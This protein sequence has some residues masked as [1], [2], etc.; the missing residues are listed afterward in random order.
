MAVQTIDEVVSALDRIIQQS[1]DHNSRI[2]YFAALYRRVTC[3]VR[4]GLSSGQF[5]NGPLLERLDVVFASRYLDALAAFQAGAVPTRSWMQAFQG[6]DDAGLLILQQLLSGMNAHINLDLGIASAQ[7]SPGDQ[8]PEL[9]P[10]FD[11]IN[12]VLADQV[13]AVEAEIASLSPLIGDLEKLGLRTETSVVN[14]SLQAARDN[15]W[16]T[17]QGLAG[18]PALL[19]DATI[20]GLDL[21]V[22]VKGRAIVHPLVSRVGLQAIQEAEVKDVRRVIE[23]LAQSAT[24]RAQVSAQ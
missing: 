7:V 9:K 4:D 5:Q 18:E 21:A 11:E 16:F 12:A 2:G 8:L 19:Q 23:V 10:D 24:T 17:A 22:T 20:D 3:A 14:F 1:Y 6:C 13:G 15:A